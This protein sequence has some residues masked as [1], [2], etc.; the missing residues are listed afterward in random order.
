MR[1][2]P[3]RSSHVGKGKTERQKD[4]RV[5]DGGSEAAWS[6]NGRAGGSAR[7][8]RA[9]R[10]CGRGSGRLKRRWRESEHS[11]LRPEGVRRGR[12][13]GGTGLGAALRTLRWERGAALGGPRG[14]EPCARGAGGGAG[15]QA[16]L[17]PAAAPP[18]PDPKGVIRP[19]TTGISERAG[20]QGCTLS[21]EAEA[22]GRRGRSLKNGRSL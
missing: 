14:P 17:C 18:A 21:V 20:L 1:A 8:G 22:Q 11:G 2:R 7:S 6:A 5:E 3:E 10:G 19:S 12:P 9:F 15:R 16:P 4:A 13:R